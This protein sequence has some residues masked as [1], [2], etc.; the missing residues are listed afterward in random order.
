MARCRS[1]A[2]SLALLLT[3]IL[4]SL[5]I[6]EF[7]VRWLLPQ[8]S[9]AGDIEYTVVDGVPLA[10]ANTETIQWKNT[11]DYKVKVSINRLGLRDTKDLSQSTADDLFVVGDSFSLG[12]GV[13]EAERFSNRLEGLLGQRVFNVA[14]P[15]DIAGYETLIGYAE[16][17]GAPVQKVI[18]AVCMENDIGQY[19]D[20]ITPVTRLRERRTFAEGLRRT[21][22]WLQRNSSAYRALGHQAHASESLQALFVRLGIITPTAD[23]ALRNV[24]STAA[25]EQSAERVAAIAAKHQVIT[26]IIP[27][28]LK[29]IGN[30]TEQEGKLHA[31]FVAHLR[32]LGLPV[33]DLAPAFEKGGHPMDYHFPNDGHWTAKG[34]ALAAAEI[35]AYVRTQ[36]WPAPLA[37][38]R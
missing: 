35:A 22:L 32:S 6:L 26:V 5:L 23:G 37:A 11:G 15:T 3:S 8:Y 16:R 12:H 34:H 30:N 24:Y 36:G 10:A 9:A 29:W 33:V 14:I 38:N 17:Q 7:G 1:V 21:K 13:E 4:V 28:R 25:I 20:R 31:G 27:S 19:R 2:L 18:L